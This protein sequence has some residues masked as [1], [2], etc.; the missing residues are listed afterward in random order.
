MNINYK[1]L[2]LDQM[3]HRLLESDAVYYYLENE[4]HEYGIMSLDLDEIY[5]GVIYDDCIR[6]E[7]E[8]FYDEALNDLNDDVMEECLSELTNET[9]S[10]IW[11]RVVEQVIAY[12]DAHGALLVGHRLV[13]EWDEEG[14]LETEDSEFTNFVTEGF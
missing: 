6:A 3:A 2:I 11:D 5:A 12:A 8:L 9:R 10:A 1:Q 4:L 14:D 13:F 7:I